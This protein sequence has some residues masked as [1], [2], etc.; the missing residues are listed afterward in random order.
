MRRLNRILDKYPSDLTIGE[1]KKVLESKENETK[2]KL[3]KTIEDF[4][5]KFENK[6][7]KF[8]GKGMLGEYLKI[9]EIKEITSNTLDTNMEPVFY[10]TGNVI[11]F[12]KSSIRYTDNYN[13][14]ETM[15]LEKSD[16]YIEISED[17]YTM[18]YNIYLQI[19]SKLSKLL[20]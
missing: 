7:I 16:K 19:E 13:N 4:K 10:F 1:L 5:A 18:C 3:N 15:S 11:C 12:D 8:K 17:E 20:K 6:Y 2:K 9:Y 14:S